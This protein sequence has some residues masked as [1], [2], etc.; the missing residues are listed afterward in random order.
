MI[1]AHMVEI[2]IEIAPEWEKPA[3]GYNEDVDQNS[4]ME[5]VRYGTNGID[6]IISAVGEKET[7][8]LLSS[9]V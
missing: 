3:E 4:D 5:N 9:V 7:L 6:R 1:F 8:P 2:P